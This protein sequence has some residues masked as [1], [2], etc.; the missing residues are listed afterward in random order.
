MTNQDNMRALLLSI[1]IK[2]L[3]PKQTEQRKPSE[4]A[5]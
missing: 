1:W 5:A 3:Q 4:A 2:Q